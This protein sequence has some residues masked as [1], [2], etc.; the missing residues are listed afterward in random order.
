M[1]VKVEIR[2][3]P[4]ILDPQ[5]EA[6]KNAL[7]RMNFK[8]I[9]SLRQGKLIELNLDTTDRK[10]AQKIAKKMAKDLLANPIMETFNIVI[11]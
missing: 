9:L 6:V 2:L 3:K 10:L 4:D 5:G 1:K 8:H 11:E 7:Q